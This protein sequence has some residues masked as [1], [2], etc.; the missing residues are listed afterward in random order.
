MTAI[1]GVSSLTGIGVLVGALVFGQTSEIRLAGTIP[2]PAE[3]VRVSGTVAFIYAG[4]KLGVV[5][6]SA[7][8]AP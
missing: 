1:P 7:P 3:S 2:G 8:A 6:V 4:S 5:D